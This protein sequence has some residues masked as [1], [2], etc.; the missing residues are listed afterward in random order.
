MTRTRVSFGADW[1]GFSPGRTQLV[2]DLVADR[3]WE[4]N[5]LRVQC[6]FFDKN[7]QNPKIC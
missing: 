2:A 7:P 3:S 4:P 5:S 1:C 6:G